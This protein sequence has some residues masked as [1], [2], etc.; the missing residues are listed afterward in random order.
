MSAATK[1]ILAIVGLLVG[2]LLAMIVLIAEAHSS[3]SVIIPDYYDKASHYDDEIDQ[4]DRNRALGWS[5]ELSLVGS[6]VEVRVH[7]RAGAPID[8]AVVRTASQPRARSSAPMTATFASVGGGVYR[9]STTARGVH[10]VTVTVER[11]G[12]RFTTALTVEVP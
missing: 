10:D 3:A 1:W 8:G 11:A 9:A 7:D 4:A 5:T 12:D 6:T 2:N